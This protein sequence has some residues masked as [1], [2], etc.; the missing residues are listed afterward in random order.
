MSLEKELDG[1]LSEALPPRRDPPAANLAGKF[2]ARKQPAQ[3]AKPAAQPAKPAAQPAQPTSPQ[4]KSPQ[5]AAVRKAM[6]KPMVNADAQIHNIDKMLNVTQKDPSALGS[7]VQQMEK[8]FDGLLEPLKQVR[9]G[10][11]Q[12]K[13]ASDE[14]GADYVPGTGKDQEQPAAQV[15]GKT[16][17]TVAPVR[18]KPEGDNE[19]RYVN[20][21]VTDI[22]M[23]N[24]EKD[25]LAA[26]RAGWEEYTKNRG[27]MNRGEFIRALTQK[28]RAPSEK[29]ETPQESSVQRRKITEDW[30]KHYN[31]GQLQPNQGAGPDDQLINK[32]VTAIETV[33]NLQDKKSAFRNGWVEYQ[34]AGGRMGHS[35]FVRA[36][37]NKLK[38]SLPPAESI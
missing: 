20:K 25:K 38:M 15:P 22:E 34:S 21:T 8:S 3:Q 36:V 35:E 23:V 31:L 7:T 14:F 18:R 13:Q 30:N 29:Q 17:S 2:P 24:N 6:R 27:K 32:V 33:N 10:V 12:L 4:R 26:A 1:I 37:T 9:S 19:E 28:L 11:R 16:P 5:F